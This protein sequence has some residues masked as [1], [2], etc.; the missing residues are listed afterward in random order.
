MQGKKRN[1]VGEKSCREKTVQGK[2]DGDT[3]EKKNFVLELNGVV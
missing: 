3:G 1:R 2:K